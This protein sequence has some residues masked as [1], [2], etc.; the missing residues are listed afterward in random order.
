M[1]LRQTSVMAQRAPL[2]YPGPFPD[3][4]LVHHGKLALAQL[5]LITT[6][7]QAAHDQLLTKGSHNTGKKA[8]ERRQRTVQIL[9][10]ST[11]EGEGMR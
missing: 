8:V 7:E 5:W 9:G 1:A 6:Q 11:D 2:I 10:R 3:F 4:K